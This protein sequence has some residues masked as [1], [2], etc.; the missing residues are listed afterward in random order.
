MFIVCQINSELFP[1]FNKKTSHMPVKERL[2]EFINFRKISVRSFEKQCGLSYGYV[3]N[4]RVSLQPDKIMSI[5]EQFP[6]LNTGWLLTGTGKMLIEN[7]GSSLFS[8]CHDKKPHIL[9][10]AIAGRLNLFLES[11]T[12]DNCT[13]YPRIAGLPDY[14]FTIS[15]SGD[16]MVDKYYFGDIVACKMIQERTFFQWGRVHVLDTNQGVITKKLMPSE[17]ENCVKAVSF[18]SNYPPFDIPTQDIYNYALVVGL[19]RRD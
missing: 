12:K 1:L 14:D 5:A 4:M 2:K 17:K 13:F 19:V 9:T 10:E 15:I 18:N 3:S 7:E 16:S 8:N 6:E 11:V